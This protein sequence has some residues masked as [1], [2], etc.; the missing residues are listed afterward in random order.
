MVMLMTIPKYIRKMLDRRA[1]LA[2]ELNRVDYR[3]QEWL[4]KN[5]ITVDDKDKYMG[6]EMLTDPYGSRHRIIET[7]ERS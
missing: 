4:D 3:L 5:N 1:L 2:R 7:I 6:C